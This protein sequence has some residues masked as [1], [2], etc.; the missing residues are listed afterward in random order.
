MFAL[1]RKMFVTK[2]A[3]AVLSRLKFLIPQVVFV[4]RRV[5]CWLERDYVVLVGKEV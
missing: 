4:L 1:D 5:T 2:I 3:I